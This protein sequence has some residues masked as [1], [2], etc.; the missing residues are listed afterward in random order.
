MTEPCQ[1]IIDEFVAP[2]WGCCACKI[3]LGSCYNGALRETCKVCGHSRCEPLAPDATNGIRAEIKNGV[4]MLTC[5]KPLPAWLSGQALI[6]GGTLR[7][8]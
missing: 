6:A 2:G 7:V 1:F 3:K 4:L 5:K 8:S